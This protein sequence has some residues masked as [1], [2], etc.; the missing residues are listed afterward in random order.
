MEPT[1]KSVDM[2]AYL[3]VLTDLAAQ[4]HTVSLPVTGNSMSPFLVHGRDRI[5]LQKPEG[6]LKRGD[7]A[8]FR[9]RNG[10]YVMHRVCRVDPDGTCYLVGD[11]QRDVEGPIAPEQVL[12]L[13]VRVCRKG[14]W[15]G[16]ENLLWRFFAGP[17]LGLRPLRP[18]LCR[19]YGR[20]S[21]LWRKGGGAPHGTEAS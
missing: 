11:G 1:P 19:A 13:V 2:N 7:M 12:G 5:C 8:L 4:G 3:P 15:L 21:R 10:V 9:R 18:L 6:P 17:W 20:I 14:R 16:P